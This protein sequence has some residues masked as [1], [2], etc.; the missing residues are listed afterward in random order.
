MAFMVPEYYQGDMYVVDDCQ[1]T[2]IP[3]DIVGRAEVAQNC[4]VS[5]NDVEVVGGWW[6]RLGAPGYMDATE[7]SGPF[8]SKP[9]AKAFVRDFY[10]VDPYT[11]DPLD[12][13]DDT[14][15]T[16]TKPRRFHSREAFDAEEETFDGLGGGDDDTW[17][18]TFRTPDGVDV[19]IF[20]FDQGG[21]AG[22]ILT[23][24]EPGSKPRVFR[25]ATPGALYE[26]VATA[27][28]MLIR[29]LNRQGGLMGL[30]SF[31][32]GRR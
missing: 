14:I 2:P 23:V 1:Y 3:T 32:R 27:R 29:V 8:N 16:T 6:A 15:P 17:E 18:E 25:G 12:L 28:R 31:V 21:S 11:G 13:V 24:E 7:W 5:A 22:Y 30:P 19:H 10:D 4:N 26:G 20:V 9:E